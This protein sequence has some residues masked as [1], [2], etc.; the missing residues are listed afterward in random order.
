[1]LEFL[2]TSQSITQNEALRKAIAT[3]NYFRREIMQGATIL[4]TNS[5][6]ESVK[7]VV[8]R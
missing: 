4:I 3:E 5:D 2:A 7:E 8:L 1:M 6:K